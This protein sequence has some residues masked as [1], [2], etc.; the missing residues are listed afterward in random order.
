MLHF[1]LIVA[2]TDRCGKKTD[3]EV[4]LKAD[5][6]PPVL[7]LRLQRLQYDRST[8]LQKKLMNGVQVPLTVD[9]SDYSCVVG[10]RE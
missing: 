5:T 2:I 3:S 10:M 1:A 6:L 8:G 4:L 7:V 9:M